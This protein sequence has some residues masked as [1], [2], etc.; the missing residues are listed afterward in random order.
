MKFQKLESQLFGCWNAD[1]SAESLDTDVFETVKVLHGTSQ[2]ETPPQGPVKALKTSPLAVG[3]AKKSG[4]P[5]FHSMTKHLVPWCSGFFLLVLMAC[6]HGPQPGVVENV[7]VC[8]RDLN[9]VE[10]LSRCHDQTF[11][12]L[13]SNPE[14]SLKILTRLCDEFRLAR[15]CANVAYVYESETVGVGF[16]NFEKS[17]LYNDLGCDL[18][19][20]IACHNLANL[21]IQGRG[22]SVDIP[23]GIEKLQKACDLQY[24]PACYRVAQFMN[25]GHFLKATPTEAAMKMKKGCDL[26]DTVSCHDLGYLYLEG[27]GVQADVRTAFNLFKYSCDKGLPRGCGSLAWMYLQGALGAPEYDK[28]K[29]YLQ[30]ACTGEDATSCSTLGYM[31]EEGK[32][33]KPDFAQASQYYLK[34]CN[35]GDSLGCGNLGVL[36]AQGKGVPRNDKDALP[37]LEKG[38][39]VN[40]ADSCRFLASFYEK[41]RAKLPVSHASAHFYRLKACEVG[42]VPSCERLAKGQKTLCRKDE[43]LVMSCETGETRKVSLC[44]QD[45]KTRRK[46]VYRFGALQ[47]VE[48]EFDGRFSVKSVQNVVGETR[49]VGFQVADV[50]YTLTEKIDRTQDPYVRKLWMNVQADHS[51]EIPCR[52]PILGGLDVDRIGDLTHLDSDSQ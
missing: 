20:G 29:M 37:L 17:F 35:A 23:R 8:D 30:I 13:K 48:L 14:K 31:I 24:G 2:F 33:A 36:M 42:D 19:E 16:P 26:A 22:R 15:A 40:A 52:Y 50:T 28:A 12:E 4:G 21:L 39:A 43:T 38:C 3:L 45:R 27:T 9:L 51:T 5:Y 6:A 34:A 41:G 49:V 46:M 7:D 18:N 10:N 1:F 47:K 25:Q 32:G 44:M 11:F